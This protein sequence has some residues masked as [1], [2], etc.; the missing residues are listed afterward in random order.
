MPAYDAEQHLLD[1]L[2]HQFKYSENILKLIG[3]LGDTLQDTFD[4]AY[5]IESAVSLDDYVGEQLEFWGELIGVGRP[6]AQESEENLFTLCREGESG[7]PDNKTGF[8]DESDTVVTG[9]Y[10][11][12]EEGLDSISYPGSKMSDA[13]YRYLIRQKAQSYR[14]RMTHTNLFNYL[15]A[16]GSRC[17]L[18]GTVT[19]KT[20]IEPQNYY[21]LDEWAKNYVETRGF[22]PAGLTVEFNEPTENIEDI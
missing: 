21:D 2:L 1:Q 18:D 14:S 20:T 22:K 4:A 17:K 7:D 13:D 9:G 6:L 5:Y 12:T 15:L 16:F 3:V 11:T 10:L 8:R 19:F